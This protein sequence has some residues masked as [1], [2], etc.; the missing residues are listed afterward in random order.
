MA[1]YVV[2]VHDR[3]FIDDKG[4]SI[5]YSRLCLSGTINGETLTLE[6]KLSKTERQIAKLI[7]ATTEDLKTEARSASEEEL[8]AFL[9]HNNKGDGSTSSEV[10][11]INVRNEG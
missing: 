3:T 6:F 5:D 4:N 9:E 7:L 8:E 1:K 11:T 2:N 10:H